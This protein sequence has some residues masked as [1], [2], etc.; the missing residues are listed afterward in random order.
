MQEIKYDDKGHVY[1]FAHIS[2][3]SRMITY[4]P[5]WHFTPG[6]SNM[7]IIMAS[8]SRQMLNVWLHYLSEQEP[9]TNT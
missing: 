3:F 1:V 4:F 7:K 6:T 2:E 9:L 5:F 8:G